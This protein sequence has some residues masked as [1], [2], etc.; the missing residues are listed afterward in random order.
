MDQVQVPAKPGNSHYH[1]NLAC[2]EAAAP[3]IP[4][5]LEVPEDVKVKLLDCHKLVLLSQFGLY[6]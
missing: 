6:T 5:Q 1:L 2:L 3:G 4:I